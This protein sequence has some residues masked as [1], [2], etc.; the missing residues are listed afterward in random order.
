MKLSTRGRYGLRAMIFLAQHYG[1][2]PIPL[3]RISE[4]EDIP[5]SYLEQLLFLLR[6]GG[7]VKGVKGPQGGYLLS[8]SPRDITLGEII[9]L[10][11]GPLHPVECLWE[12]APC[13]Q[14]DFCVA[15]EIWKKIELAIKDILDSFTLEDMVSRLKQ[16]SSREEGEPHKE[17]ISRP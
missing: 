14:A 3:R 12:G 16:K 7:L 1:Q 17:D 15:R 10:L 2:G 5:S 4:K 13:Q 6:R 11:E 8:R 9:R